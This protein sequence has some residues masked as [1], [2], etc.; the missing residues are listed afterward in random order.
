M[1]VYFVIFLPKIPYRCVQHFTWFWP[2]LH[3]TTPGQTDRRVSCSRAKKTPIL[4]NLALG[5]HSKELD[6]TSPQGCERCCIFFASL[7]SCSWVGMARTVCKH[8][9]STVNLVM[10]RWNYCIHTDIYGSGQPCH[11]YIYTWF[12][13]TLPWAENTQ[14]RTARK[15]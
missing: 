6:F 12:W 3:I 14:Q 1:T 4:S 9:I 13:P 5:T 15:I 8:R 10:Y 2:T 11:I 7:L